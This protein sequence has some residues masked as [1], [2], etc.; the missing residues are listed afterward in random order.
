MADDRSDRARA[1]LVDTATTL[2]RQNGVDRFDINEL[3]RRAHC[4]RATVYRH[5]G[6]KTAIIEAV[7]TVSS[8]HVTAQ[9][10]ELTAHLR[11]RERA[12]AAVQVALR[13]IRRDPVTQQLLASR[14]LHS[15]VP[16]A[17]TSPAVTGMAITLLG[18]EAED[19]AG[20]HWVIRAFLALAVWPMPAEHEAAAVRALVAGLEGLT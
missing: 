12:A 11:G 17:L 13:E 14:R 1:L 6:G 10:V 3:A 2:L 5:I 8:T 20:A 16:A 19:V 15:A 9:V 7:L 4:S 18:L